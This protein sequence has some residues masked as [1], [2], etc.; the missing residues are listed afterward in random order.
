[1]QTWRIEHEKVAQKPIEKTPSTIDADTRA[2][3]QALGY[4]VD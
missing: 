2:R 1:M 4:V 3:L